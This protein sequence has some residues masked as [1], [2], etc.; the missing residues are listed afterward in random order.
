MAV[1]KVNGD[2]VEFSRKKDYVMVNNNLGGGSF[3]K[4][5]L[6]KDEYIDELF[7]AKKYDPQKG[8]DKT[9]FYKKFLE[10]IKI[11]YK[12]NHK[13]IVRIY[14]YYVYEEGY[15]GY[16]LME[17][18]DG[19]NIEDFI[20]GFN[21]FLATTSLDDI[22]SQLIDAF[23]YLES[24]G[25]VHRDIR[26]GNILIDKF[27]TVKVI[28]FGI[29]KIFSS[30]TDSADDSDSLISMINRDNSDTL[31]QEYYERKYTSLTDMF[32]LA[33]L[34][35]RLI[36]N[37]KNFS[38]TDFSYHG[39]IEKMMEKNPE[40]RFRSFAAVREAIDKH[41]FSNMNISDEDKQIYRKFTQSVYDSI[42]IYNS[43]P[44]FITDVSVFIARLERALN[45]NLFED[46]IQ[47]NADVITSIIESDF[48]VN[49][50]RIISRESAEEFFKWFSKSTPQSQVLILN[51][52]ISKLLTIQ[53]A[54][55]DEYPF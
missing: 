25:I 45:L 20:T 28:D 11:L 22:F 14:N 21:P 16:I 32:Y 44:K 4:T 55:T 31:P 47:N 36:S 23:C 1:N 12:L 19:D 18:I 48:T 33:E 38:K 51:N 35:N 41:D 34:Y 7:V 46:T 6:L 8:V 17:Y 5:V 43:T 39:I 30:Y 3:G 42:S 54:E 40:N 2:I 52:F 15:T 53:V 26:E 27:G 24:H 13:N 10:E 50:K 29:G 9:Q 49:Q 37:A